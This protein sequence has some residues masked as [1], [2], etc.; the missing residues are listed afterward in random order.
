[1]GLI[2]REAEIELLRRQR[3]LSEEQY[4]RMALVEGKH[5]SGK[6]AL[7]SEA[8]SDKPYLYFRMGRKTGVL[9]MEEF[10]SQVKDRLSLS[11]PEETKDFRGLMAFLYRTSEETPVTIV[12]EGFDFFLRKDPGYYIFQRKLIKEHRR[13]THVNLVVTLDNPM[14]ETEIFDEHGSPLLNCL[15]IKINLSFLK[16]SEMKALLDG[17][18]IPWNNTDLLNLYMLTGGYQKL[19]MDAVSLRGR[20][21]LSHF[22]SPDSLFMTEG[23]LRIESSLGHNSDVYLSLLE[24]ISR[25]CNTLGDLQERLG[26]AIVGGHLM[27][28]E[29]DYGLIVKTRPVL[30]EKTSRNVVRYEIADQYMDFWLRYIESYS[31]YAVTGDFIHIAR[32]VEKESACYSKK[33]LARYFR[34]L[35]SE[36]N[37]ITDI[38]GDW[39]VGKE[40]VFEL[41]IVGNDP[42]GKN[43]LVADV[44]LSGD[45]FDK[46]AFL[47]RIIALRVGRLKGY[48]IDSRLLTLG[49]M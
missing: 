24:L 35:F 18:G 1:M 19:F 2:F 3:W 10:I 8:F 4:S 41:D 30:A 9:Q 7:V 46:D 5:R 25:G 39:R 43:A 28:L 26:G 49:D 12:V 22:L 29:N 37:G 15:D 31:S 21:I 47:G 45:S 48:A 11:V 14:N 36:E 16:I 40:K 34:Q 38:G 32:E 27:K 6:T 20:D 44:E 33:V 23:K 42:Q 17:S 13:S